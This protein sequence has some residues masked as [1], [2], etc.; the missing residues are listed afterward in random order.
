MIELA[1]KGASLLFSEACSPSPLRI[2]SDMLS[3]LE[4]WFESGSS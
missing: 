2:E 4:G 1:S 3:W